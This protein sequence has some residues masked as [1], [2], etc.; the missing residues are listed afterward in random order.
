MGKMR[1]FIMKGLSVWTWK[2][3][4]LKMH[5]RVNNAIGCEGVF[6]IYLIQDII[7]WQPFVKKLI[8][9]ESYK[10]QGIWGS[11]QLLASEDDPV[12]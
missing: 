4:H 10:R 5:K 7:Q 1:V 11:E 8:S 12:P 6:W 2:K 3:D 9:F